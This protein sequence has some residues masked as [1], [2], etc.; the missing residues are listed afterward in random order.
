M[1]KDTEAR[2]AR[3]LTIIT[4]I[5]GESKIMCLGILLEYY[6]RLQLITTCGFIRFTSLRIA[7]G[8]VHLFVILY[9]FLHSIIAS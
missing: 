5:N 7:N 2:N 4:I 1:S 8:Y 3:G 9:H 6:K